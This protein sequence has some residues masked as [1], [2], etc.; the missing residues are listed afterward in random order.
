MHKSPHVTADLI[1]VGVER[2]MD[3]STDRVPFRRDADQ[4][5]YAFES[6]F[7]ELS[8]AIQRIDPD[9]KLDGRSATSLTVTTGFTYVFLFQ[10]LEF[11]RT[12]CLHDLGEIRAD[13]FVEI[14]RCSGLFDWNILTG[15]D[16]SCEQ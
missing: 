3:D 9:D 5:R 13:E 10:L 11:T 12:G 15:D 2:L 6:A 14:G 4:N 1:A 7:C 8:R 16:G